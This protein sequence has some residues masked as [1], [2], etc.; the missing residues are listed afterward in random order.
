MSAVFYSVIAAMA[1]LKISRRQLQRRIESMNIVPLV[2]GMTHRV[3]KYTPEQI[4][5]LRKKETLKTL[6]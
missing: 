1:E 6:R 5:L 3:F 2:F 4:E